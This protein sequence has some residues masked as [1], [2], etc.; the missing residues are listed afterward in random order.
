MIN[1]RNGARVQLP[2]IGAPGLD[3]DEAAQQNVQYSVQST[4]CSLQM[5]YT[6]NGAIVQLPVM[7]HQVKIWTR[8]LSKMYNTVYSVPFINCR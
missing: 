4:I 5:I 6:R 7:G 1:T 8:L 3:M 2:A